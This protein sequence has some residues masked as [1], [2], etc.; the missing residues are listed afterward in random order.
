MPTPAD[1][2]H[3]FDHGIEHGATHMVVVFDV[4]KGEDYP[5]YVLPDKDAHEVVASYRHMAMQKVMEVY[6]LHL[7]KESQIAESRAF[8]YESP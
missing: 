7:N 6:A 2:S 3:W 5:V 1:L 8:H 4:F